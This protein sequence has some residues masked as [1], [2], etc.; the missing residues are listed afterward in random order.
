MKGKIKMEEKTVT[1]EI[2]SGCEGPNVQINDYRVAGPK[3]W[4][5]GTVIKSFKAKRSD[6]LQACGVKDA[7]SAEINHGH[8][9]THNPDNPFTIYGE[10]SECG[11]KPDSMRDKFNYCPYCGAKMDVLRR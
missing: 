6:I 7:Q 10:C 11:F 1:I 2:V 8:W 5:G 4:G 3:S 9:I